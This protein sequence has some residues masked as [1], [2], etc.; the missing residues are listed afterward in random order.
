MKNKESLYTF[1]KISFEKLDRVEYNSFPQKS[2]LTTPEWIEFVMD[3][4]GAVPYI[5]KVRKGD[6]FLGF[7]TALRFRRFGVPIIGSP[8]PGW[9]TPYMG[10]DFY[11]LSEKASVIPEL[12]D[13]VY[14]NEKCLF[15]QVTDRDITFE[16][17]N[18]LKQK[19]GYFIDT[20][21][22]LELRVDADDKQLYKNM[23]TDCRNFINQFER[24][25]ASIEM[26]NPDDAFAEEYY[27]QLLDVFAKQNLV[28]T[29]GVDLVKKMLRHLSEVGNILCLRVRDPNGL[30]IATSIFPGFNKKFFFM[31]GASLRPYQNYRPNE[32]M[33]YTAMKYWRDRGCEVFDMVGIRPYKKKF[34]SWE[35]HYPIIVVPKFKV[36]Y[37][38]K[39]IASSLYYWMGSVKWKLSHFFVK[40]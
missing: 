29:H 32:Y 33:I 12:V 8:F 37:L 10:F 40:S 6:S 30:S 34:G 18:E 27:T 9:S 21:D 23:K 20:A 38:L 26:A 15:F 17:A 31:M 14:K 35:V 39:N 7:F 22:T 25:G 24:R 5:L 36:L 3:I 28:P 2:V 19:Y 1:E 4:S 11:D 13:Y 16:Q